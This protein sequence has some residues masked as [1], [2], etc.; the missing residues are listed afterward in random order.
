MSTVL[1]G[2]LKSDLQQSLITIND[3]FFVIF[4]TCIIIYSLDTF[5]PGIAIVVRRLHYIGKS[6]WYY[7]FVLI[8]LVSAIFVIIWLAT[9]SQSE[10]NIY[11]ENPKQ[12]AV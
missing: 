9:D 7:L 12:N 6:G 1:F 8:P 5:F 4:L 3:Y 10:T 2:C 11:D